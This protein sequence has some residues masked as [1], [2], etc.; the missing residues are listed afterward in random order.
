VLL[1][2]ADPL[3]GTTTLLP[4]LADLIGDAEEESSDAEQQLS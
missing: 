4:F 3:I 2:I 1:S